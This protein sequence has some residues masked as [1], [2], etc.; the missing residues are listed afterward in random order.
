VKQQ[1]TIALSDA[2]YEAAAVAVLAGLYQVEPW[3]KLLPDLTPQQQVQA[4]VLADMWQLPTASQTAVE[5]LQA[6]AQS[7][8]MLSAVLEQL[9]CQ[10]AVPQ[11]LLPLFERALL[12]PYGD[13][14]AVWS[15]GST[16]LQES[17]LAL[18]LQAVELLLAS[19]EHYFT[20]V[21]LN[22]VGI[23]IAWRS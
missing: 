19:N 10:P 18:P 8:V 17:L 7:A 5:I 20:E 15:P 11:F 22:S 2:S 21:A 4:A 9:L 16:S 3:S 6:A 12:C 13:L 23:S 14:E 1:I